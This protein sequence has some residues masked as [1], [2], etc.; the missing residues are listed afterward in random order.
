M[1]ELIWG[2]IG[3]LEEDSKGKAAVR[4]KALEDTLFALV[5]CP[6]D[7]RFSEED[8]AAQWP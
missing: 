5:D 4:A 8:V 6:F 1:L 2:E 3:M 7:A